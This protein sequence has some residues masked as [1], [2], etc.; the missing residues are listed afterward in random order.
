M[1]E[2]AAPPLQAGE[3]LRLLDLDRVRKV[4]TWRTGLGDLDVILGTP[5]ATRGVLAGFR[6]LQARAVR[7]SAFGV[8]ILVAPRAS[9]F[10]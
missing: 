5:T 9:Q 6:E 3:L 1:G 7:R 10:I 2:L 8:T 4:S